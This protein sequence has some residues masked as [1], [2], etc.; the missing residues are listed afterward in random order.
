M[1]KRNHLKER[2]NKKHEAITFE[3]LIVGVDIAKHNQWARFVDCRGIEHNKALK[4]ENNRNGFN[5]I[6]TRIYEI[7]KQEDFNKVIVGMEPTGHYWKAFANFLLKQAKITVVLVNPYHTKKAKE[8]DDNSQTKSD[9]KDALTIARLVKDGRYF[10]TY[11]PHDVYAELRGLTTTRH[12]MNKRKKSIINTITAV[13]DE[14]FP[15]YGT[16]FKQPFKGKASMHLL[17][18]CPIPKFILELGEDG[19]LDEIKKAVKKTVGRKKAAQLLEAAKD[20]IGVD[21]GEKAA[22]FKI[23][24]LMEELELITNQ[25]KS[26]EEEMSEALKKTEIAEYLMSIPGIGV[27]SLAT[28]LGELGDPL[29]FENARQMSRLAGYNLIEDSSG[30]N[31][32]GTCISKRGRKNLR[33]VLYQISLTMVANNKELRQLYDYLKTREKNP[34]KKMQALVVISKKVLTLIFTLSKKK[35]YYEP[36][37]V[38][39]SYRKSQLQ[40]A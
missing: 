20:S 18:V 19:V 29:R 38:F 26:V 32:S 4:F 25:L 36:E 13:L 12:S 9:K 39:G 7:C 28:C 23:Q 3:T 34:L 16:V 2:L 17:K 27:V 14:Y 21:Y 11:L 31:K 37:L 6:L 8:L 30:K 15:E 22:R 5:A 10:E 24:Q 33:S 1:S 35:A 40:A